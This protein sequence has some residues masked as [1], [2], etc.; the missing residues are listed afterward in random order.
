MGVKGKFCCREMF[1]PIFLMFVTEET[2]VLLNFL[3]LALDF[4]ITL[5]VISSSEASLDTKLFVECIYELGREL[6]TTIG[7]NFLWNSVK[8]EDI[9]VVKIGSTFGC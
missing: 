3:I 2:E 8:A 6:G 4:A 7:E 1:G 9:L 5:G